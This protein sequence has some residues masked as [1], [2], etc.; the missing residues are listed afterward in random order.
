[1][2]GIQWFQ[3]SSSK[4]LSWEDPLTF[5][6]SFF[7]PDS[8]A[9]C[10]RARAPGGT[11]WF[12]LWWR[13]K[14]HQ[15]DV[16]LLP[17]PK[18]CIRVS[19]MECN[20]TN[21]SPYM[22]IIRTYKRILEWKRRFQCV[23][24]LPVIPYR[25][26]VGLRTHERHC[27]NFKRENCQLKPLVMGP[28]LRPRKNNRPVCSIQAISCFSFFECADP[29]PLI[30]NTFWMPHIL[31]CCTLPCLW[32]LVLIKELP[33]Q[34]FSWMNEW[35]RVY[36][37]FSSGDKGLCVCR[38][39]CVFLYMQQKEYQ[40]KNST[41]MRTFSQLHRVV[42]GFRFGSKVKEAAADLLIAWRGNYNF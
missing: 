41:K 42:W 4:Y 36:G 13:G 8:G 30:D 33:V 27:W 6:M 15:G 37:A 40:T 23:A 24:Q 11:C 32:R 12:P 20:E 31:L 26:D 14:L 16:W 34:D 39:V 25:S 38:G 18:L 17:E 10:A 28:H 3:S 7:F 22:L 5:L 21:T 2:C 9:Q 29:Q 19:A 1:M 35:I